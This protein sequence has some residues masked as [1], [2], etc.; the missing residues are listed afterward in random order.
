MEEEEKKAFFSEVKF[1]NVKLIAE[2]YNK[3]IVQLKVINECLDFLMEKESDFCVRIFCEMIK[4]ICGKLYVEDKIKL[5]KVAETLE[6]LYPKSEI[7]TKTKFFILDCLDLRK[8]SWGIKGGHYGHHEQLKNSE[9]KL[10]VSTIVSSLK[11]PSGLEIMNSSRKGSIN[12]TQVDFLRRSRFNSR[13]DELK[14][15]RSKDNQDLM[16]DLVS[17]LGADIQFYQCFKLTE[18]EFKIIEDANKFFIK[19]WNTNKNNFH[20]QGSEF[21]HLIDEVPCEKF[22]AVGHILEI[23]FSKNTEDAKAIRE[24]L[25]YLYDEKIVDGEDLKHGIVLGLVNFRDN[26]IDYP[27]SKKYLKD[28]LSEITDKEIIDENLKTVYE[29]CCNSIE[30]CLF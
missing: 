9:E 28:F 20:L 8:I 5:E 26:M 15:S 30:Q 25:L 29:K 19:E 11:R 21:L 17:N 1:G 18:E 22:I 7:D 6:K 4:K 13:A 23:M 14:S 27:N 12:P 16:N 24:Y 10:G 3:G 2:F